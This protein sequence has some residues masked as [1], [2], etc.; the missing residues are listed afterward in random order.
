MKKTMTKLK[1]FTLVELIVVMAII[2]ILAAIF[3]PMLV[4]YIDVARVGRLNTN[5]R[6]VY[7]AAVYAISDCTVDS[8][9]GEIKPNAVYTGDASDLVAYEDGGSGQCP[10]TNYLG[11]DFTG[12]FA[13]ATDSNGSCTYALWSEGTIS[14]SDV[15]QLTQDDIEDKYIGCYPIK[16]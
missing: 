9:R 5:A 10:M 3:I 15:A 1:G 8:S 6:H 7:G 2:G 4:S 16:P 11:S 13:F 12:S 14:V